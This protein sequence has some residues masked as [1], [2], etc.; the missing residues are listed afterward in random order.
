MPILLAIALGGAAAAEG[1]TV[2]DDLE[3]LASIPG[4]SGYETEL[5]GAIRKALPTGLRQQVDNLGTLIVQGG[6]GSPHRLLIAAM[7]EP[8]LVV[9]GVSEEGYLRLSPLGGVGR[10]G[11]DLRFFEG[12]RVLVR[13]AGRWLPGAVMATSI[14]LRGRRPER[15]GLDDMWV[16]IGASSP[17]EAEAAGVTKLSPLVLTRRFRALAGRRVTGVALSRR[18]GCAA[19]L[20]VARRWAESPPDGSWTIAWTAQDL[21]RRRGSGRLRFEADEV[22]YVGSFPAR[23]QGMEDGE[24][25]LGGGPLLMEVEGDFPYLVPGTQ[26]Q[27]VGWKREEM[28]PDL[29]SAGR[30]H[31]LSVPVLYGDT[32]AEVID[33]GDLEGLVEVLLSLGKGGE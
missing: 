16:D 13:G 33:T 11:M 6:E 19:L 31:A 23:P 15:F 22:Y 17:K 18:F 8:G 4:P 27:K 14:H 29:E 24:M 30:R 25:V 9:S 28:V 10:G 32:P 1:W 3:R 26:V 5:R 20:E 2:A 7:D 21:M 12:K